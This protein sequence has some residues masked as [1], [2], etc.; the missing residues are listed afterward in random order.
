[1]GVVPMPPPKWMRRSELIE[2]RDFLERQRRQLPFASLG[3][4]KFP[5]QDFWIVLAVLAP[6]ILAVAAKLWSGAW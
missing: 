4:A 2:Y 3:H 6:W 1:M 5:S